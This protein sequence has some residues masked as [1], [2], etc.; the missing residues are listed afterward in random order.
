MFFLEEKQIFSFHQLS[1]TQNPY[2][3]LSVVRRARPVNK[4]FGPYQ[5]TWKAS[6]SI[7]KN[8]KT[9][10]NNSMCRAVF[11]KFSSRSKW[12]VK[13]LSYI[14]VCVCVQQFFYLFP[15]DVVFLK[16]G[17]TCFSFIYFRNSVLK[18]DLCDR[19]MESFKLNFV[20]SEYIMM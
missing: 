2:W 11:I 7:V 13:R 14:C 16:D 3:N 5:E 19:W 1:L 20:Y 10:W 8:R 15:K 17:N 12:V 9:I 18:I 6:R 4:R